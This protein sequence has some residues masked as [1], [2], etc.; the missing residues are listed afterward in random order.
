MPFILNS[1]PMSARSVSA[2]ILLFVAV[3]LSLSATLLQVRT[4]EHGDQDAYLSLASNLHKGRGFVSLSLSP[5][6][7]SVEIVHP[8][9]V[10]APLYPIILSPLAGDDPGFFLRAKFATLGV[11][12]FVLVVTG[13]LLARRWGTWTALIAVLLLAHNAPFRTYAT[14]LWC[15]NLLLLFVIP[16]FI[17]LRDL[18]GTEEK[19]LPLR[20]WVLVGSLLGLGY[21]TK[22]SVQLIFA[23][24]LVPLLP[25]VF[26]RRSS[27][28]TWKGVTL[29]LLVFLLVVAP[30]LIVNKVHIGTWTRDTD[31][32]G[33]F[34]LDSGR[35]YWLPHETGY[36]AVVYLRTHSI[37]QIVGRLCRGMVPQPW[38]LVQASALG[39]PGGD[40][41]GVLILFLASVGLAETRQ[42]RWRRFQI[43]LLVMNLLFAA[44]YATIDTTPRFVYLLVPLILFNAASGWIYIVRRFWNGTDGSLAQGLLVERGRRAACLVL[45]LLLFDLYGIS[46]LKPPPPVLT[47]LEEKLIEEIH[48]RVPPNGVLCSGPTHA[49]PFSW[50]IDRKTVFLPDYESW[51]NVRTYFTKY[52]VNLFLLDEQLLFRRP[53]LFKDYVQYSTQT[54]MLMTRP[55]P[56][57]RTV[58]VS[59][60]RAAFILFAPE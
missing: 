11:S 37:G 53:F 34:W 50:L 13:L 28:G 18:L 2:A 32:K 60:A 6:S 24:L 43:A 26:R 35:D 4:P 30:Y 57:I 5:F 42:P 29:C 25:Y 38:N 40:A 55:I 7:P 44:W 59:P 16:A 56:D 22:T 47:P 1:A 41:W 49:V 51:E 33:A 39:I 17:F 19:N 36:G 52:H 14:E 20:R 9:G 8:E 46:T 12:V 48:S 15:E 58:W 45:P 23:A 54:G 10:R 27:G 3:A 21:L 31:L